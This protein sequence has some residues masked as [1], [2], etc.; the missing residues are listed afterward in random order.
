[1]PGMKRF[2]ILAVAFAGVSGA[3]G[4]EKPDP[5]GLANS[6]SDFFRIYLLKPEMRSPQDVV[7]VKELPGGGLSGEISYWRSLKAR[8]PAEEICNAYRWLLL[9]RGVYGKGAAAAFEKF[10]SLEQV[11]LKFVDVESGTKLGKKRAEIVP[12]QKVVPYLRIGVYRSSLAGRKTDW[13][14]VRS[15]LDKG[16]CADVAKKYL[17]LNWIEAAYVKPAP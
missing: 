6:L 3:V 17:D 10:P 14:S 15:D 5:A 11:Y 16:K 4:A 2:L 13:G 9:G 12:T 7:T 1:M 8:D